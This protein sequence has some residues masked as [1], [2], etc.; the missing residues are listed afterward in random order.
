MFKWVSGYDAW[1]AMIK[2]Y[3]QV[4]THQRNAHG[5]MTNITEA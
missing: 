1:E 2:Q 4:V 3:W 5:L